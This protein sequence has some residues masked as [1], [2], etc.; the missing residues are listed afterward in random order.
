[1]CLDDLFSGDACYTFER[2]DCMRRIV[3]A[4]GPLAV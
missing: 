2:V 3:F 4:W 1:M